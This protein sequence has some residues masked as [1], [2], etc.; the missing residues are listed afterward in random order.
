MASDDRPT[1]TASASMNSSADEPHA[2][3]PGRGQLG[4]HR[5]EQQG[6]VDDATITS[7]RRGAEDDDDR[8]GGAVDR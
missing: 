1:A 6:P 2:D 8:H 7:Q 5:A 3:T 4:A